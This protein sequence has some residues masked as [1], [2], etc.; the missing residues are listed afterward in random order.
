MEA[1]APKEG[2]PV[3]PPTASMQLT[4][5]L[6]VQ[7]ER[8]GRDVRVT[9]VVVNQKGGAGKTT[10]AVTLAAIFA[11][12]GWV[13]RIIDGDPQRAAAS[14]WLLG[15]LPTRDE[16]TLNGFFL[17]E[18]GLDDALIPVAPNLFL[19]PSDKRLKET[20]NTRPAGAETALRDAISDGPPVITIVDCP[21][22]LGLLSV[23]GLVAADKLMVPVRASGLD[24]EGVVELN[25]TLDV[26]RKR[27]NPGLSPSAVLVTDALPNNLTEDIF[28]SLSEEYPDADVRKIR[29]SVRAQEAPTT[30][31]PLTVYAPESTTLADYVDLADALLPVTV[32][33]A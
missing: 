9:I 22:S 17:D 5:A 32:P 8:F 28:K 16:L 18:H 11:L 2:T 15:R 1:T 26:V 31:Q 14:K 27:L 24:M 13:V 20:E 29:H 33:S 19:V 7:V 3:S 23:A 4:E 30:G 6:R 25:E 12:R 10:T 21:P